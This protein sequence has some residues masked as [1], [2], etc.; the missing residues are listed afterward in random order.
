MPGRHYVCAE[1]G[2]HFRTP[3]GV[4]HDTRS[5]MCPGCGSYD[6]MISEVRPAAS[7]VMRAK[8]P[9]PAGAAWRERATKAS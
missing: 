8:T 6:L 9:A 7:I 1:C 2:Y 5:L 3:E 4:P